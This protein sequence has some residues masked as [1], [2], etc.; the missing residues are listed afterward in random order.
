[1]CCSGGEYSTPPTPH[2]SGRL[3][4]P[5]V[6]GAP[7]ALAF[8]TSPPWAD[9]PSQGG[10]P[11][12][13]SGRARVVIDHVLACLGGGFRPQSPPGALELQPACAL[14]WSLPSSCSYL[15]C[16]VLYL[17]WSERGRRQAAA[18]PLLPL[19]YSR[20][21]GLPSRSSHWAPPVPLVALLS[22]PAP[23]SSPSSRILHLCLSH[24][25][26]RRLLWHQLAL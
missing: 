26:L 11:P 17:G 24:I 19:S 23:V 10:P 4:S 2:C 25:G 3:I 9:P 14:A 13:P 8:R 7:S 6:S 1:M 18:P 5:E 12:H 22:L 15:H 21:R 16:P 20:C